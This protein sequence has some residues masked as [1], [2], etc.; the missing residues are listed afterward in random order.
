M[1]GKIKGILTEVKGNRGYV[2]TTSGIS[3][4]V[5]LTPYF[6][7]KVGQN[8]EPYTH[9]QIKDDDQVLF[10]FENY[11]QYSLFQ[12]LISVDGVGPKSAFSMV[13]YAD[14][15]QLMS[16]IESNDV[17]FFE[18]IPGVG[19]KTASRIILDLSGKLA[20]QVSVDSLITNAE[21]VTVIEALRSL[22]FKEG[23]I[24]KHLKEVDKTLSLEEK[25]KQ[26]IMLMTE[27]T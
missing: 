17:Y 9:F 7:D 26:I 12:Q 1:I 14:F 25:I 22:G 5:Y 10:G 24:K 19:K 6:L 13:S 27:R 21:D 16:A 18:S 4:L 15:S 20:K 2:K 8:I 11:G 23:D 3:Y